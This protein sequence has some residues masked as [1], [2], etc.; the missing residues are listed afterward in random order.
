MRKYPEVRL[1][2]GDEFIKGIQKSRK[3]NRGN[4]ME[5][6]GGLKEKQAYFLI[7]GLMMRLQKKSF[8]KKRV[9]DEGGE[10]ENAD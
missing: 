2:S 4:T 1:I 7:I 3:K 5:G 6:N 9:L 10:N 8:I